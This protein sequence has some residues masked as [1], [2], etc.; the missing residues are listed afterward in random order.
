MVA[1]GNRL[2]GAVLAPLAGLLVA[3]LGWRTAALVSGLG[4]L[5]VVVPLSFLVLLHQSS[6]TWYLVLSVLLLAVAESANPL[7]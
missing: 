4:I 1:A 6:Q 5:V 3:A 7:N 2:G